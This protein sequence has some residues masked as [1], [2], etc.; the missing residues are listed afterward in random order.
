MN[1]LSQ[2]AR[3]LV[4]RRAYSGLTF[5]LIALATAAMSATFAV[6]RATLWRD[7][8]YRDPARLVNIYTTEPVNRDSTQQVASSAVM[9]ARWREHT[10]MLSAVEG[11]SPVSISINSDGNPEALTAAA[12]SAGLFELLGTPPAVGRSFRRDEEGPASGVIVLSD[13]VARQRFGTPRDALSKTLSIDREPLLVVGVMQPGF[14]LLFHG[15]DAWIPLDLTTEQQARVG[16]RNI[17]VYGRLRP[18][19]SLHQAR[20]DLGTIERELATTFP[21][22]Y[23]ATR[24]ALRPLRE[25][26]FGNRRPT[27]LILTLAVGLVLLIAVVNVANLTLGDVLSRR[28]MT[29]TRVALGA[30]PASITRAR[31]GE[32]AILACLAF[33]VAI[34]LA[35]I[36]LRILASTSPDALLPLG[37]H[38]IDGVVVLA[39]M[40]IAIAVG[41]AGAMPAIIVEARTQGTGIAGTIGKAGSTRGDRRLRL[42]LSTAQAAVTVVLLGLGVLLG[43][44]LMRLMATRTGLSADGVVVVRMNVIS[45]ERTTVPLRAQYAD[46]LVRSVSTVPGV[47]EVSAIQSRFVLNESMQSMIDVDG[48]VP[49]PGLGFLSARRSTSRTS[50][51][52][53]RRLESQ[54]S[55]GCAV[56][57]RHSSTEFVEP[58]GR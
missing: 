46:E 55:L 29:M 24:V 9:L 40:L 36:V 7:L 53:H 48:F 57:P 44:D 58:C 3:A 41:L 6:V 43:R 50:S 51:R 5:V 15:G 14:S 4:R 1:A 28:M 23:A 34:P 27:M 8:P 35:A 47:L 33:A 11:Y 22:A 38:R 39:T 20:A 2:A 42:L 10:G 49:T 52:T 45:R 31:L 13:A 12:V 26:L 16:I 18:G 25:A 30:G 54:W 17:A 21:N 19:A 37:G 56:Q 32:V